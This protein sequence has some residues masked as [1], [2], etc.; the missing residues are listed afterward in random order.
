[1]KMYRIL[2]GLFSIISCQ[3]NIDL[4]LQNNSSDNEKSKNED[5]T[6]LFKTIGV[7]SLKNYNFP[8]EWRVNTYDDENSQVK[9]ED[10]DAQK[11][12]EEIDYFNTIKGVKNEVL[13]V[14]YS[15]FI[16]KD[17]VLNLAK[18]DSL[19]VIDS[20]KTLNNKEIK[21]FKTVATLNND[22]YDSPINIYK[23]DLV[24][25]NKN[26]VVNSINIY[27][28]ID[29]PYST[30]QNICYLDE[31]GQL[32]C[33]KFSIGEEKVINSGSYKVDSKKLFNIK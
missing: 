2:L 1:M 11:R 15:S 12:L 10:L 28:E 9:K 21:I 33:R 16:K 4:H 23:I 26:N 5:S 14:N 31:T 6:Y 20:R 3:K 24:L 29:F 7:G 22:Q 32:F 18:V 19:F 13:N 30:K 8:K 17:S 27:S 25:F